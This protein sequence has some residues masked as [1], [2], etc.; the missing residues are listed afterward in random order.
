M[1][2]DDETLQITKKRLAELISRFESTLRMYKFV[3]NNPKYY[4]R[5]FHMREIEH[6]HKFIQEAKKEL[7]N[8]D[9]DN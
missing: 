9:S 2:Q 7:L 3:A 5:T 6:I 4:D 1:Q 8:E